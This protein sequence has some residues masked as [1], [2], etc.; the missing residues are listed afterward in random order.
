MADVMNRATG[1]PSF[2]RRLFGSGKDS[3]E[4][5]RVGSIVARH[6]DRQS[7]HMAKNI[8]TIIEP[9]I[10]IA[11]AGIVLLVALSVFLPMWQMISINQ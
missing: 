2:A 5:A 7:D 9:M 6:Y 10:T 4:L 3:T 8:N 11:M 1:L